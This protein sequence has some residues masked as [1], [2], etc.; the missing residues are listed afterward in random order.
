MD[1]ASLEA[2]RN[3]QTLANA[4]NVGA[5]ALSGNQ[6]SIA[7][8]MNPYQSNVLDQVKAQYGDLASRV[9]MGINDQ[10]TRAGAFGGSR[11]GVA[12]G[13]ALGEL[14][15]DMGQQLAGLQYQGYN[16]A[17][18]RAG[19]LAQ[20]GLGAN[21]QLAQLGDYS[22]QVLMSQ[23]PAMRNLGILQGLLSGMPMGM[24]TSQPVYSNPLGSILGI[25]MGAA[26][27]L[28]GLGWRPFGQ[29]GG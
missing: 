24:T 15:K 12:Q 6:E 16:D 27:A 18:G 9:S 5:G 22:R 2:L 7:S 13:V 28:G 21:A 11:H 29:G 26:G 14:G 25:G 20:L 19:A 3:Y 1:P 8:L 23:D 10:A 17:M 4:S